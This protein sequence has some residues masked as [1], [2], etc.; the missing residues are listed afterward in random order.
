MNEGNGTTG[1]KDLFYSFCSVGFGLS[2]GGLVM[3]IMRSL[4][5]LSPVA[6]EVYFFAGVGLSS[7][8]AGIAAGWFRRWTAQ[9]KEG[10][11]AWAV[12]VIWFILLASLGWHVAGSYA[13]VS[14]WPL[15][16]LDIVLIACAGILGQRMS[17]S[18]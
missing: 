10:V 15:L 5:R 18:A 4:Q 2:A 8:A 9:G 6:G 11:Y 17:R 12:A 3:G 16:M 14:V 13:V 1:L 7:F